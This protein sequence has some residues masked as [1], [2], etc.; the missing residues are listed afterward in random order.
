M[1]YFILICVIVVLAL[2]FSH[3]LVVKHVNTAKADITAEIAK[4]KTKL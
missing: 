3:A 2:G 4:L 1:M